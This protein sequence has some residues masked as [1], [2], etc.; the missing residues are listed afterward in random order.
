M[1]SSE[2]SR[3][4]RA[5]IGYY[6]AFISLGIALS[7]LGATLPQLGEQTGVDLNLMGFLFTANFVGYLAGSYLSGIVYDR[8]PGHLPLVIA[9]LT[10]AGCMALIP[11]TPVFSVLLLILFVLGVSVGMIDVGSNTLLVWT[12]K[13]KVGPF[14]SGLHSFFGVGAILSPLV[15]D[16]IIVLATGA[17]G[18]EG[19]LGS[20]FRSA[21][22]LS[23]GF[24]ALAI[25][26]VPAA[27]WLSF[28]PSPKRYVSK[29]GEQ[30]SG[31]RTGLLLLL[32]MC[33]LY[34]MF[35]GSQFGFGGWINT[36]A[37]R[38]LGESESIGRQL[39]SVYWAALALGR[40]VA[41][42]LFRYLKAHTVF[43]AHLAGC[44]VGLVVLAVSGDSSTGLWLGTAIFGMSIGPL[45]PAAINMAERIMP[46]TGRT[47]GWF[48]IGSSIGNMIIPWCIGQFFEPFGHHAMTAVLLGSVTACAAVFVALRLVVRRSES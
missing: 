33:G 28:L 44:V 42:P 36:F 26:V 4:I 27:L 37:V 15:I 47:T 30:N 34:F 40:F 23:W 8:F 41:I 2:R 1:T 35:H 46:I 7:S 3:R 22:E 29:N 17:R 38:G 31:T 24:W 32:L 16:R 5:T 19:V 39:T 12:H 25:M 48:L 10:T 21:S 14:M 11:L 6:L 13:D 20:L 43:G 18:S 9:L 45:S